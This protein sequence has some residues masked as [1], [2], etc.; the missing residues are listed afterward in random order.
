LAG[1]VVFPGGSLGLLA[2]LCVFTGLPPEEVVSV[3]VFC[4]FAVVA[5]PFGRR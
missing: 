1:F 4:P 2:M 3:S 5:S